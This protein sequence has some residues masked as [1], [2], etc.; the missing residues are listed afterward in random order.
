MDDTLADPLAGRLLDGRYAVTARIAHGGMATVYLALDTRLDRQVALKVMHAELA[1]DEDFVRRFI[2]EAKS[3]ARLSHQNVVA[4]FDQGS[5]GPFL[6]LA[7]E[8][9]PGRT[10]KEVLRERGRFTPAAALEIMTGVLDGLAAAHASGIVHRD[11]KPENVLLTADGRLKVADFGLAR[12]QA[13]AG[14]T[15]AGL[16][17]GTVAYLPP[18]QVTG[19]ATGPRSDVYS[20]GVML[21]EL[22]TGRQ[23]FTGDSP[24]AVAYQHVNQD[25]PAPSALVPGIPAAVDQLVLA[26]TSRDPALRPAD[27]GEFAR[28]V[29]RVRDVVGEPS[30]LTGVMGAG[31]QG[32]SEA[33]WLDLDT[34]AATNG[35]WARGTGAMPAAAPSGSGQ[36]QG[37]DGTPPPGGGSGTGPFDPGLSGTGPSGVWASGLPGQ[38]GGSSRTLVVHRE[39]GGRYRGGR[40]PFLQRWLFSPRLAIVALVVALCIGLGL[41]GWWLTS[42]RYASVPVVAGD[43]VSQATTA[44]TADGFTVARVSSVHSNQVAKGTVVGTSPSGRASKGAAVT[45]LISSGPFTSVVPGVKGDKLSV[46]QAALQ[47][48]HLT[49]TVQKVGSTDPVGTVLG[50]KPAGGTS[51]PQ[52]KPVAILVAEGL[53]IPNFSGQNLQAAQQWAQQHG[54]NLQQQ[55]DQNSS[56]PSGTIT[57]QEPAAGSVY[58]QGETIEVNV[59]QGPAEVN[60]PD[61]IG[62]PVQAA[63]QALQAAGFKSQVQSFG[64]G[65]NP[66][67]RVWDYSP[68]GQAPRGSTILLDVLPGSGNGGGF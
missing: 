55:P 26:A 66:N 32:L 12:A 38:D 2:G 36:W 44:L 65:N 25:V 53:P 62:M 14:Q 30:R 10:L 11:V 41:G 61:V 15:R 43:S 29:R 35:W 46:A 51:W 23:P 7:M 21:F 47:R 59:S 45:I 68:V 5:D 54:A 37:N 49:S 64:L 42:G 28:A 17:I 22:L 6:Y 9:V 34:P 56:Q 19:D 13:A 18:E 57:G 58:H 67:G 39:D 24:I 8:Y 33:P 20:A 16:L 48:V 50:T 63:E 27:A 31:V 4:V 52:T 40:E 60:V 1:R 3:V